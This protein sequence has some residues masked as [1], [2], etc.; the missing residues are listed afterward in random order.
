MLTIW[1]RDNLSAI[2]LV[3]FLLM[4]SVCYWYE[5]GSLNTLNI[6]E[7]ANVYDTTSYSLMKTV[8]LNKI[9]NDYS[10]NDLTSLVW[11]HRGRI[12]NNNNIVDGST[13]ALSLLISSDII[14]FDIDVS[15]VKEFNKFYVIHPTLLNKVDEIERYLSINEFLNIIYDNCKSRTSF[16]TIEPKFNDLNLLYKLIEIIID[17]KYVK[18]K[19]GGNLGIIVSSRKSY[20]ILNNELAKYDNNIHI[21]IAFRTID[22]T[23]N[24][25]FLWSNRDD[26]VSIKNPILYMPDNKLLANV[27][28][29]GK[30]S[31]KVITWTIDRIEDVYEALYHNV[32]GIITNKPIE[33]LNIL[34]KDYDKFCI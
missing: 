4:V 8:S 7:S 9:C 31:K 18:N 29:N 25:F 10:R 13:E 6:K 14:N 33:I 26:I 32:D 20:N 1:L 19:T 27:V 17:S 28:T 30:S 15:F 5:I 22:D 24:D 16:I 3:Y 12:N 2:L 23:H 21:A 34:Q 11:S